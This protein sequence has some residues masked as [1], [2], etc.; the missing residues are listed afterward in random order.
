VSSCIVL[1]CL[2][3]CRVVSVV[4]CL[5]SLFC[6]ALALC[7]PCPVLIVFLAFSFHYLC[8]YLCLS[9]SL[10]LCMLSAVP[11]PVLLLL[12]RLVSRSW[13]RSRSWPY[14][15]LGLDLVEI[16][17]C[18]GF[19]FNLLLFDLPSSM[20]RCTKPAWPEAMLQS[21]RGTSRGMKDQDK[22]QT[23]LRFCWSPRQDKT[24][25]Q[26]YC[27]S[28]LSRLVCL[29]LF[30]AV[31]CGLLSIGLSCVVQSFDVVSLSI[32]SPSLSSCADLFVY[33]LVSRGVAC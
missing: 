21:P 25:Q 18:L 17:S 6:L 12:L 29:C 4:S 22:Y 7:C 30:C 13:S 11:V 2:D 27:L 15:G 9:I 33:L 14:L 8:L 16:L 24:G 23:C 20:Q 1:P 19:L 31:P 26:R 28:I 5:C 32:Y 10:F 3:L